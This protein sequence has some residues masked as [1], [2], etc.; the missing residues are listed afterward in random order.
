[1]ILNVG[2]D[3]MGSWGYNTVDALLQRTFPNTTITHDPTRPY[4]LVVR[5]H[6]S[7]AETLHGYTGPYITWSGESSRVQH[8]RHAKPIIEINTVL[9][10]N[11]PDSFYVPYLL[12]EVKRTEKPSTLTPKCW[13]AAYAFSNCVPKRETLFRSL[14]KKEKTCYAFGSSCKTHDNPFE[15]SRDSRKQNGDRFREF[16]FIVAMEN[17]AVPGYITEKIGN[18][19]NTGG[20]PIYWGSNTIS[21][22]FNPAAFINIDEYPSVETATNT[23]V[24]IWRDKQKLQKYL[25]APITVS[26]ILRDYE[27][28]YTDYRPW[29]KPFVDRL[30]EAF[31]DLN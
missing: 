12:N 13:C 14:R 16:G 15:L 27:A 2:S 26:N 19:F 8:L 11:N 25:D 22:F 6:F 7:G 20:V 3:G 4:D 23:I 9:Y 30:R 31:P 1:M 17:A 29:Q 21:E 10:P 5:S 28:L 18:A 24:N